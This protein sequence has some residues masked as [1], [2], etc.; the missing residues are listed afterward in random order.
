MNPEP[1]PDRLLRCPCGGTIACYDHTGSLEHSDPECDW[2]L[3]L[4]IDDSLELDGLPPA[5]FH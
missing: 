5:V 3:Q 2:Y 1:P 4:P